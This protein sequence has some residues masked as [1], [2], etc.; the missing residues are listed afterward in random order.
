MRIGR[1]LPP[2]AAPI[3]WKSL[4]SSIS[5]VLKGESELDRFSAE[6]KEYFDKRHCFLVS[7]GKAALTLILSAL[8]EQYPER[9]EV[10]ISAY[11]CYSVPSAIVRSGLKIKLCDTAAD[12]FDFDFEQLKPL[13]DS[14]KLLCVVPT[15]LFGLPADVKRLKKMIDDP[16]VTV[17]EDAAQA[18]GGEWQGGKLGTLGDVSFFSLGRGKAFSTVEGG[19]ILTDSDELAANLKLQMS[20]IPDYTHLEVFKLFLYTVILNILLHPTLFWIPKS[21]PFL[22]LGETIFDPD[23]K[24]TKMSSFQAGLT[25]NWVEKLLVF[26]LV[27]QG[28]VRKLLSLLVDVEGYGL[29]VDKN[30]D[31]P[32][33]IRFPIEMQDERVRVEFLNVA[34]QRGLGAAIAYPSAING[35]P[36]L[37]SEFRDENYFLAEKHSK[38]LVTLP[39]HLF[40]T[41]KDQK[42]LVSALKFTS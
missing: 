33:L 6:L 39:V 23:F 18:M 37:V 38:L 11:T 20:K 14:K 30:A 42:L 2:A 9:D 35:I 3:G 7:S 21:L 1:T 12:S 8:K 25:K 29:F 5:T 19:V 41:K 27:R 26:R 16:E 4:F 31:V 24:I 15:H 17:I 34:S 28:N 36:E 10:I 40:C 32:D 22:K 13:L